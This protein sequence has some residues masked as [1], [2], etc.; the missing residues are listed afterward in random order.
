MTN[1]L[2][3]G[4]LQV[5]DED[6]AVQLGLALGESGHMPAFRRR[7]RRCRCLPSSA[8]ALEHSVNRRARLAEVGLGCETG[9]LNNEEARDAL[10]RL[11]ALKVEEWRAAR[12]VARGPRRDHRGHRRQRRREDH[13][14]ASPR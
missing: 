14:S 6:K 3:I 9:V 11:A 13:P 1:W 4:D 8:V 12:R 10:S 2:A 7:R 5:L